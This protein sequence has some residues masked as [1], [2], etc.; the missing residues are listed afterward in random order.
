MGKKKK[1][2]TK[3]IAK[4]SPT[5]IKGIVIRS[6]APIKGIVIRSLAPSGLPFA[7]SDSV[8][9]PGPNGLGPL[10]PAAER[11]TLLA[12]EA[13]SVYQPSSPHP[14]ADVAGAS[15][16][17]TLPLTVPPMEETGDEK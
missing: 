14:D 9:V 17:E 16:A 15:C 13:T 10:M 11:L 6:P 2:P 7:P 12:K 3:G 8:R 4:K 5:P 1:V